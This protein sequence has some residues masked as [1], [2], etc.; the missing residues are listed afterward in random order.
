MP[1]VGSTAFPS[2]GDVM[3][4]VR[5]HLN[6]ADVP[7]VNIISPNGAVR[8]T[9]SVTIT[10]TAAHGIQVG[11]IVQIANVID[12][13]FNGTFLVL[14]VPTSTTFIYSQVAADANSGTGT[15]SNIIQGDVF[16]DTVLLPF[17]NSAY[18]KVQARLLQTGSKTTNRAFELV[19]PP[20]TTDINDSSLVQLPVDFLA[21]RT[22]Q[23]KIDGQPYY[24]SPMR[25]VDI[26]P[27]GPQQ[28]YNYVW[29]WANESILFPG[30]FN[31]LD[32]KIIYFQATLNILTSSISTILIRGSEDCIANWAA[33]LAARSRGSNQSAAFKS[34][35]EESMHE[36]Q[37]MQAH[38]RQYKPAR[39]RNYNRNRSNWNAGNWGS[40]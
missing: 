22:I 27:S 28:T 8:L 37:N 19:L 17:V 25:Q 12:T 15:V 9:D 30:S 33:Y 39:R 21:P 5:S 6:D 18:R 4:L 14:T 29:T 1:L 13:S 34:D 10:T 40:A 35:F 31:T 2:A 20:G 3:S 24:G 7:A 11:N 32:I 26:L 38:S 16:T 36:L 23:E